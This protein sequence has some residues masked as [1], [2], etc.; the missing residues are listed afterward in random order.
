MTGGRHGSG[1]GRLVLVATP[2]GNLADLSPCAVE[3]L[4]EADV[5]VCEDTRRTGRLLEHAGVVRHRLVVANEHSEAAAAAQVARLLTEGATVAVVTD[6]GTPGISDPGERLVR[7]AVAGGHLV[8]TVPGPTAGISAL[9]V[10]GLPTGRFVMEGFLP[11]KGG[12]RTAR[13]RELAGERRT[14][15]L[16]EAPHR[17]ARTLA[18]LAAAFGRDR[19]IVVCRELTK[20]HEQI[21][22]GTLSEA[23]DHASEVAPRGEYVLVVAGAPDEDQPDDDAIRAAL[24]DRSASG[25]D[26]R[27]AIVAVA[28]ELRVPKRRVYALAHAHGGDGSPDATR[29]RTVG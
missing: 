29:P 13:L 18:D 9:V 24:A 20:L 1:A 26:R 19:S 17:L 27:T 22:R 2:I 3:A 15:V 12:E 28:Q 16:Y 21:W 25:E 7:A 11:R 8:T 10:S 6:A 5:I 14:V 4:A 23:L